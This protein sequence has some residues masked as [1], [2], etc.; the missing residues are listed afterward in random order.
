M[1]DFGVGGKEAVERKNH[2]LAVKAAVKAHECRAEDVLVLD[3]RPLVDYTDFFVI[4]SAASAT[5]IKGMAREIEK[6][7][8]KGGA[9]LISAHGRETG[10]ILLDFGDVIVHIFNSES[11]RFYSLERLWADAKRYDISQLVTEG[12]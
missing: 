3:M 8:F 4:A 11:R 12:S 7:L 10:W 2:D 6:T 5:Q 9:V 1:P